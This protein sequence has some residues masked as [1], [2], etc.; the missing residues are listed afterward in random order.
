MSSTNDENERKQIAEEAARAMGWWYSNFGWLRRP[1][2]DARP[3]LADCAPDL[4]DVE[5]VHAMMKWV[6]RIPRVRLNE[7]PESALDLAEEVAAT[8]IANATFLERQQD[9]IEAHPP[10]CPL[11]LSA[12]DK[13]AC[14]D[15]AGRHPTNPPEITEP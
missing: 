13:C 14:D 1:S 3:E 9:A 12:L 4:D 15:G 8:V 6:F 10:A 7:N 5:F 2:P 11:C